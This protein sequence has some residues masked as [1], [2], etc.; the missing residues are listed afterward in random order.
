LNAIV[1]APTTITES[2]TS[3]IR[4]PADEARGRGGDDRHAG[5]SE[6]DQHKRDPAPEQRRDELAAARQLGDQQREEQRRERSVQAEAVGVADRV[7][8]EHS[9]GRADVPD[10]V[11][12]PA[13]AEQDPHVEPGLCD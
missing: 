2:Q 12:Q 13:G 3:L 10:Q 5:R 9:D 8:E 11:E 7:A 4:S 6:R 1:A